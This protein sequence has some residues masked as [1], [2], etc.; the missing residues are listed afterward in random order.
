MLFY[1]RAYFKIILLCPEILCQG[2]VTYQRKSVRLYELPIRESLKSHMSYLSAKAITCLLTN[3]GDKTIIG[4]I[5]A[6]EDRMEQTL[7]QIKTDRT[8]S[9][10]L[11]AFKAAFPYT[12]PVLTG[13]AALGIAYGLLMASNGYGVL[14]AFLMSAI[15]FGGSVQYAMVPLLTTVF[16]PLQ[17]F[18]LSFMINARHLFYGLSML[19]KYKGLGKKRFFLIFALCDETFSVVSSVEPPEDVEKGLFYFFITFL[20]YFYWSAATVAVA[21]GTMITRFTPFLLFPDSKEPPKTVLYLGRVLPPAM[22]GLLVVYCLR[23]VSL[24]RSPHGIPELIAIAVIVVLHKWKENVL[25][26]I[27]TGTVVY[28]LLVQLVF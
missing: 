10:Y 15:G 3:T 20:D 27:G 8:K 17:A 11:R 2:G 4:I 12:I 26:S 25:L 6:G 21:L 1:H 5:N 19:G 9:R 16:D 14:W 24:I 7:Q 13:F 22:M 23:N 18:L 28:M